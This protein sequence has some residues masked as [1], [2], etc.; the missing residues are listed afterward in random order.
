ML[1]L[2]KAAKQNR[3]VEWRHCSFAARVTQ[4]PGQTR[5]STISAFECTVQ[6]LIRRWHAVQEICRELD[7][8][9]NVVTVAA[10]AAT[11]LSVTL[12]QHVVAYSS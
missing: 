2:S 9:R 12:R 5:F 10:L 8:C 7:N 1:R 6:G 4:T 11:H 3:R